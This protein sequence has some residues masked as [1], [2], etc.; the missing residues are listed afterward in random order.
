MPKEGYDIMKNVIGDST[1]HGYTVSSG[2][3]AAKKGVL[4]L[5]SAKIPMK[6]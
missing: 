1:K 6:P 5:Y 3:P 2:H 4:N